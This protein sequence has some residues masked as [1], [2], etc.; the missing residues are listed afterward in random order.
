MRRPR[1]HLWLPEAPRPPHRADQAPRRRARPLLPGDPQRAVDT[2]RG[3]GEGAARGETRPG[4]RSRALQLLPLHPGS[5]GAVPR[6]HRAVSPAHLPR[7]RRPGVPQPRVPARGAAGSP[8]SASAPSLPHHH[9]LPCSRRRGGLPPPVQAAAAATA[10]GAAP[11]RRPIP[12]SPGRLRA[13]SNFW[14]RPGRASG[15][16]ASGRRR[17]SVGPGHVRSAPVAAAGRS[18]PAGL[19]TAA[20]LCG[21]LRPSVR[22]SLPSRRRLLQEMALSGGHRALCSP[23]DITS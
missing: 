12:G 22:P 18:P 11:R 15:E 13:R 19:A 3:G 17:G 2:R 8:C 14:L 21:S 20:P 7:Q 6:R 23:S 5:R 1:P 10:A 9:P 16:S 4:G